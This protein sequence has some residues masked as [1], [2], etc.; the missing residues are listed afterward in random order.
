MI[1]W[2]CKK[3]EELSPKT[4]ARLAAFAHGNGNSRDLLAAR[5]RGAGIVAA[6]P[7]RR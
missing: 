7:P 2:Y 1:C 4:Y 3:W 6:T 5:E